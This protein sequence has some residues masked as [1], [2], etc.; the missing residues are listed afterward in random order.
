MRILFFGT[1]EFALPSLE[2]LAAHQHTIAMCVTQPDRPQGRG[3]RLQ[4]P[5]VKEAALRLGLP[6]S[7]P[8]RPTATLL[9]AAKPEVGVVVAYGQL[10]RRD[11]L[12][13]PRLGMVGVH[14]S[15]LPAY[16][17]AAPVAWA[18]FNG[19]AT[20]GVTIF[21]LVERL[22]AGPIIR[23]RPVPIEPEESAEH[24]TE[25]LAHLGAEELVSA[26][27]DL[28]RDRATLTPQQEADASDAPKLTKAQ[29][30]IDWAAPAEVI[31]RHVRALNPWPGAATACAGGSMK[32][33]SAAARSTE[34]RAAAPGTVLQ[35]G[36]DGLLIAAGTGAVLVTEVQPAGR[37]RMT[38]RE[39]LAGHSV[40]M[41]Q[42][43]GE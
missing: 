26:L 25:R 38:V 32:I 34:G 35:A 1:S 40:A 15:L 14:P 22:D 12:A 2:R 11:L 18:I 30:R 28:A 19:E 39:F 7:Q 36:A 23:Q 3:L 9:E 8:E 42:R 33:V 17:G 20:T 27:D 13:L 29:G 5:P 16:R 4:P 31:V 10:I 41:G 37:R 21:R 43:L 24:L 6:V